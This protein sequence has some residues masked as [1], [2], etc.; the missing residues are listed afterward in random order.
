MTERSLFFSNCAMLSQ[1]VH[2]KDL[3][4][5]VYATEGRLTSGSLGM[6]GELISPTATSQSLH[7][8]SRPSQ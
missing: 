2:Y 3:S 8:Y 7:I 5:C 4:D 1:C 6:K